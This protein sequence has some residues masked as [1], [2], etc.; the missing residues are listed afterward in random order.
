MKDLHINIPLTSDTRLV[1]LRAIVAGS[2]QGVRRD[3]PIYSFK[4]DVGLTDSGG[5]RANVHTYEMNTTTSAARITESTMA[6]LTML[7]ANQL[8]TLLAGKTIMDILVWWASRAHDGAMPR[9]GDLL[10]FIQALREEQQR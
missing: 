1:R 5:K 7:G 6:L 2:Q 9:T 3:A 8:E 4:V 10:D